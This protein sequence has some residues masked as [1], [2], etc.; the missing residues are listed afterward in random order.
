MEYGIAIQ[1]VSSV[2][3]RVSEEWYH[4]DDVGKTSFGRLADRKDE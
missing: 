3:K 4:D 2:T 1:M